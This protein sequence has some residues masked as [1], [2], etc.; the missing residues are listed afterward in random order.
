MTHSRRTIVLTLLSSIAIGGTPVAASETANWPEKALRIIVPYPA[1]TP[2]DT[3][4]RYVADRISKP[5]GQPVLVENKVGAGGTIGTDFVAHATPDGYT[6]LITPSGTMTIAPTVQKLKYSADDFVA[7][8]QLG[9]IYAV[10]TVRPD[11][12]F[13]DFK[14]FVAAAKSNSGK[15]T[16][17]SNGTGSGTQ[18]IALTLHKQ[19]GIEVL[20]I[21]YKGATDSMTDLIGGRVDIMYA[22]ITVPQIKAGRLKGLATISERRN[23]ELPDVPTLG[24]QGFD[25]SNVPSQWFGIFAPKG[26]PQAIVTKMAEQIQKVMEAPEA[27]QQLQAASISVDFKGPRDFAKI[28]NVDAA[29]VRAFILKEG[30]QAK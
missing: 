20:E 26:T 18:L 11:S 29:S 21:P 16:F 3:L 12:P 24:E 19:A 1:G 5:L 17:A 13:A 22:P 25:I 14:A 6:F 30:L 23:V 8:S 2:P 27:R 9:A 15:Y 7:V 4:T 28:V 10:A